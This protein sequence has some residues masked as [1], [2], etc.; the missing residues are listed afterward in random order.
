MK[1][2]FAYKDVTFTV[3]TSDEGFFNFDFDLDGAV[4]R[5]KTQARLLQYAVRKIEMLIDRK[6]KAHRASDAHASNTDRS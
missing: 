4:T 6:L 5:G 3:A 2:S 1:Q